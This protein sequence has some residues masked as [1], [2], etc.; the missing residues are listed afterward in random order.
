MGLPKPAA[1]LLLREAA[2]RPYAG[3]V[4]TLGR[5]EVLFGYDWLRKAA[6][7]FAVPLQPAEIRPH[8]EPILAL[9]LSIGE[10]F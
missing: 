9:H 2:R 10:A 8:R 5:Q 3:G 4:V 1:K 7:S 6:A